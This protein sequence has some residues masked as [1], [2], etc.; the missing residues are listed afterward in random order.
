MTLD[1]LLWCLCRRI[2]QLR[3][4][5]DDLLVDQLG[6]AGCVVLPGVRVGVDSQS[7]GGDVDGAAG[8]LA[9]GTQHAGAAHRS[10]R[11]SARSAARLVHVGRQKR[12]VA[13]RPRN[14]LRYPRNFSS[15]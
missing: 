9:A 14:G 13:A 4:S 8:R 3:L 10:L 5:A 11:V 1:L 6:A 7:D 15:D 2:S 12:T